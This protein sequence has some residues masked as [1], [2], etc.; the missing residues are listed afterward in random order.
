MFFVDLIRT[1][2]TQVRD[3]QPRSA[4][5]ITTYILLRQSPRCPLRF[6]LPGQNG[7]AAEQN[8][9]G[10]PDVDEN[11]NDSGNA[12]NRLH[13]LDVLTYLLDP[14]LDVF[15][16]PLEVFKTLLDPLQEVFTL[17]LQPSP[18]FAAGIR[19]LH[20]IAFRTSYVTKYVKMSNKRIF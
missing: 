2:K 9:D 7:D 19:T 6:P 13:R 11:K 16:P 12:L 17:Q 10:G 15:T 8:Y 18:E 1:G 4:T 20:A 5:L 14:L 3:K